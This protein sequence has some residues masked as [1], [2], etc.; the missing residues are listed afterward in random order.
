MTG[1]CGFSLAD[2]IMEF[3]DSEAPAVDSHP[4]RQ[5]ATFEIATAIGEPSTRTAW[6]LGRLRSAGKVRKVQRKGMWTYA[7]DLVW[8]LPPGSLRTPIANCSRPSTTT[9]GEGS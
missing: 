1:D 8:E 5:Y 9:K 2:R 3:L 7:D 6:H 4:I